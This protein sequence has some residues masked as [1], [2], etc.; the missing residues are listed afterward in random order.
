MDVALVTTFLLNMRG[1]TFLLHPL[2]NT[3]SYQ[4]LKENEKWTLSKYKADTWLIYNYNN[5]EL[6]RHI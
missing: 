5:K 3:P 4:F 2:P 6:F 1:K